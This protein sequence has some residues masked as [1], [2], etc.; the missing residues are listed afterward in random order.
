MSASVN[1]KPSWTSQS[2]AIW[3]IHDH[4][5]WILGNLNDTGK[6][7]GDIC[8]SGMLLR[9][10]ENGRSN[11]FNGTM[12]KKLVA[13]DLSIECTARKGINNLY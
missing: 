11:Y 5:I 7:L 3:Y 4:N 6:Q 1:G 8:T 13:N 12:W 9:A 10:N 2:S